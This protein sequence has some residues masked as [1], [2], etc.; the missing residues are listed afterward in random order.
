MDVLPVSDTGV[1]GVVT[2]TAPRVLM[3]IM[4]LLRLDSRPREKGSGVEKRPCCWIQAAIKVFRV[5]TEKGFFDSTVN[6]PTLES[7]FPMKSPT[8][9]WLA[10]FNP[11]C[12]A[13]Y[14]I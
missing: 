6:R 13:E 8:K 11:A 14:A 4:R 5:V 2:F 1:P 9:S 3:V 12:R 10:C 7:D